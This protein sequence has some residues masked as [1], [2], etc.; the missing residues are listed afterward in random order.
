MQKYIKSIQNNMLYV[1]M[2]VNAKEG[3]GFSGKYTKIL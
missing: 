3:I 2:H 1:I